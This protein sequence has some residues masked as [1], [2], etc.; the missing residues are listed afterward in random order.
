MRNFLVFFILFSVSLFAQPK[1]KG[2]IDEEIYQA[3]LLLTQKEFNKSQEAYTTL[4]VYEKNMSL[5]QKANIYKSLL[6][7][8]YILDNKNDAI[9]YGNKLINL[10]RNESGYSETYARIKYRI[11]S[12]EDWAKFRYLF[13]QH[14]S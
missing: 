6:E 4:L 7:L 2:E 10:I 1:G 11:C 3:F 9:N 12:S 14:C 5:S 13:K 8:S